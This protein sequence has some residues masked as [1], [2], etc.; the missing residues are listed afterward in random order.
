MIDRLNPL[1]IAQLS[2]SFQLAQIFLALSFVIAAVVILLRNKIKA[3]EVTRSLDLSIMSCVLLTG[4]FTI[5]LMVWAQIVV[6]ETYW[7][8][9]QFPKHF[10]INYYSNIALLFGLLIVVGA[11][12]YYL[13]RH[14][15]DR[16]KKKKITS[17]LVAAILC[18]AV[19]GSF[20]SR[21]SI[22][23]EEYMNDYELSL[24]NISEG[25][26]YELYVPSIYD[27]DADKIDAVFSED[28]MNGEASLSHIETSES[29]LLKINGTGPLELNFHYRGSASRYE[30]LT[31]EWRYN[32]S[33]SYDGEFLI[34]YNSSADCDPILDIHYE[35]SSATHQ[36]D[37]W[38]KD[39]IEEEGW[40][41]VDGRESTAAM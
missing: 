16:G 23:E 12:T 29:V 32:R 34:F 33:S 35:E 10:R 39:T 6:K 26:S 22:R 17:F 13:L 1:D 7:Y 31:T 8:R 25:T 18:T 41:Y 14:V 30:I 20:V 19:F 21:S 9:I 24:E 4:A 38:I 36:K 37:L 40:Q 28:D 11:L 15:E 2:Y 3:E 27:S 5:G